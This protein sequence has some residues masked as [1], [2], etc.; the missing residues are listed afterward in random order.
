MFAVVNT[1]RRRNALIAA[2]EYLAADRVASREAVKNDPD[3]KTQAADELDR[4]SRDFDKQLRAAYQHV[5]WLADTGDGQRGWADHRFEGDPETALNGSHVWKVLEAA[6]KA[7]GTAQ[8]NAKALSHNLQDRDYGKPLFELRDDFWRVPRL[9]LLPNGE[10][11]LRTAIWE[12]VHAGELVIIDSDGVPRE[13]HSDSEI[14]LSSDMQRLGRKAAEEPDEPLGPAGGGPP[15]TGPSAGQRPAGEKQV[16]FFR[17]PHDQAPRQGRDQGDARRPP[18]QRRGRHSLMDAD[19]R[20][21]HLATRRRR[22]PRHEGHSSRNAHHGHRSVASSR[23]PVPL[24]SLNDD[25][26]AFGVHRP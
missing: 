2:G 23:R 21:G 4:A 12:A 18:Q 7:F 9:P 17:H 22:R 5:V 14:N 15:P 11:D 16:A 20:E 26:G 3:L 6:D 1:Y 19:I 8:F 13:A 10:K 25:S 24:V